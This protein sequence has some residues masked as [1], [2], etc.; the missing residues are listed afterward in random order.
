MRTRFSSSYVC[1]SK[2]NRDK[3]D[4]FIG[5]TDGTRN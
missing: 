1:F 5:G 3:P 4:Y 2:K